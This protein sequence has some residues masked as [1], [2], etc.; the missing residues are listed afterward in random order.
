MISVEERKQSL[1]P[2][3]VGELSR[4][5]IDTLGLNLRSGQ[6]I[7]LGETNI[8]H[9]LKRHP[10][11]YHRYAYALPEI[12]S[13]P[14]YVGLNPKDGSLE[15]VREFQWDNEYVKVAVR[16]SG[17]GNLYARSLYTLNRQRVQNFIVNGALKKPLTKPTE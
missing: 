17:S 6:A 7:F 15:Y 12:L 11:A 16:V 9:M 4:M 3:K 8:Q 2:G 1:T 5:V 14:D 10:A 13:E